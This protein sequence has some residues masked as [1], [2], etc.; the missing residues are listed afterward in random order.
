MKLNLETEEMARVKRRRIRRVS[1]M[2][3]FWKKFT[4]SYSIDNP[5][6]TE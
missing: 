3:E 5:V 2:P 1:R 4:D 6:L